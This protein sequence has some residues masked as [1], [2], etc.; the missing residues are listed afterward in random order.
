MS[1]GEAAAHLDYFIPAHLFYLSH[2]IFLR[3]FHKLVGI[4]PLGL[5]GGAEVSLCP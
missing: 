2:L 4:D 5:V 3:F 1:R